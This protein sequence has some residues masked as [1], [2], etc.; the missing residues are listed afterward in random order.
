MTASRRWAAATLCLFLGAPALAAERE[1]IPGVTDPTRPGGGV[2][3]RGSDLGVRQ[4]D[5]G[6]EVLTR[7]SARGI[8]ENEGFVF[9]DLAPCPAVD[10]CAMV[11]VENAN[12]RAFDYYVTDD[13]CAPTP[14]VGDV[15]GPRGREAAM[16]ARRSADPC[17]GPYRV[18]F[19]IRHETTM[20]ADHEGWSIT[21]MVRP[22]ALHEGTWTRMM[23][24][25]TSAWS[26][27][28]G[29]SSGLHIGWSYELSDADGQAVSSDTVDGYLVAS[30]GGNH[31]VT[32][33][34]RC[35][36]ERDIMVSRVNEEASRSRFFCDLLP[37]PDSANVVLTAFGIGAEFGN[38]A[39]LCE[40][41]YGKRM[42]MTELQVNHW[43]AACLANPGQFFGDYATVPGTEYTMATVPGFINTWQDL[44]EAGGGPLA[45]AST[46]TQVYTTQEGEFECTWYV[47]Y[48]CS[49]GTAAGVSTCYCSQPQVK[50]K[51]CAN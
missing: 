20:A 50:D 25:D 43:Y 16:E 8:A 28:R 51:V 45:C 18:R 10:E 47:E 1:P 23:Q 22:Q 21:T 48:R 3:D 27:G 17:F 36:A 37:L 34:D 49:A 24:S 26:A 4:V 38:T 15:S 46:Q 32:A 29:A 33:A 14:V 2:V 13:R 39:D 11:Q 40:I 7:N 35:A 6:G 31:G 19:R 30:S 44:G 42:N 41:A 9:F 12:G 5:L